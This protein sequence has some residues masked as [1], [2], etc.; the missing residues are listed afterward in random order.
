[1]RFLFYLCVMWPVVLVGLVL[2]S[3]RLAY[4]VGKEMGN[5]IFGRL[6]K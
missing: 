2:R 3:I 5:Q 4:R 1:M 6:M